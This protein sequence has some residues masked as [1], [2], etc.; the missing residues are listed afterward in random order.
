MNSLNFLLSRMARQ[1]MLWL[2]A[3]AMLGGSGVFAASISGQKALKMKLSA[4]RLTA[5][6]TVPEGVGSVTLQKFQRNGGWQ[7]VVSQ[8]AV[9]GVMTFTLPATAKNVQW[10]ALGWYELETASRSKFPVRFYKGKN[11]F[12]P[13]K[14]NG[15]SLLASRDLALPSTA[16]NVASPTT[17][18]T[19]VEADIWK[20]DGNT[21][22]FFNQLRGLQVL[23][24][25]DPADPRLTASLRLPAVGQDLYVLPSTTAD[26]TIILLTQGWTRDSG[27]WTRI[28]QVKVSGGK[29]EISFSQEVTGS[30]AD[31]RLAGNR[32]ILATTEYAASGGLIVG[33]S[34]VKCHLS[35]WL[36]APDQ[37]P[38][39]AAET[40][41][42]GSSPLIASGSEWLALAVHP[43]GQ[44]NVTDVSVFAVR[45]S[46][47]I[48]MADPIRT[49]GAVTDKFKM[50]W[51]D[52]VL[53]TISERRAINS[54]WV[55]T[56]VLENF[57]AWA[58]EVVHPAVVEQRLGRLELATGE[59]LHATRFAGDKAYVVTFLRTDPLWVV[60]LSDPANP[61]VAGQL[62]VPGW[63]S[64]LEP[65]GDMLFSIGW[66][67]GT[68]AASLFDVSNPAAPALLRRL[69]LG[70]PGTF[71]E[72]MWDE[73]ALK[74]LPSEGL[75]LI[76]LNTYD[77]L[78]SQWRPLL[79]LLDIDT[80]A[81]DLRLRG[82]IAHAFDAR[83]ADLLGKTVVSLSQRVM[84]TADITDRDAPDVL[85][86]VS[87]A[88]PVD[89]VLEAGNYLLEI[90]NGGRWYASDNR[91]T[92]RISPANS[93][94]QIVAEVDLGDGTLRTAE[95]RDGKLYV[96]RD[97]G[98]SMPM[99]YMSRMMPIF[100]G[101]GSSGGPLVLDIYDATALPALTLLGSCSITP[102]DGAQI[103]TD[104]LLWPQ[105][106]RPAV[107]LD[108]RFSY[109]F[110][111]AL[112]PMMTLSLANQTALTYSLQSQSS[113]AI[114]VRPYWVPETA[115]SLIL[116]DVSQSTSPTVADPVSLGPVG[117]M[118]N[119]ICEAANGRIVLGTSYWK[120]PQN[121]RWLDS[122]QAVQSA[123]VIKVGPT[124]APFVRP[125][126]DLP[127][128]LFAV[129]ELD[130]NGFYAFTRTSTNGTSSSLQVSACD[131][132]DAFLITSL[133]V[134]VNTV[135]AAGG[136]R[137][138]VTSAN[139]VNRHLL[140]DKG[141]LTP[142]PQL[143][144]GWA[145]DALRWINGVLTGAFGSSLFAAPG[146]GTAATTWDFPTWNLGLDRLTL[147]ADGDLLVPFGDYG[148]E[149]LER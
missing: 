143:Q 26:R 93:P 32:L 12:G 29:A 102:P 10:R 137:L 65:I 3:A 135:V 36:L 62:E 120:N 49:E 126:V 67:A 43:D 108:Y 57:R 16:I 41:I 82:G 111:G 128:E 22:Y 74:V 21:V 138:F 2:L 100:G 89:R 110:G 92:A 125:L 146:D 109:W 95:Y 99:Y 117:T 144:L 42:E 119:G 94:E 124:T 25:T 129:T 19:P 35:E 73:K 9:V 107:V 55:P 39:A 78:S 149:R 7:Q 66:E 142:E 68:V 130:A 63:S 20:V 1:L 61:K 37:A 28:Q 59:S 79:Q 24:L 90:E 77:P 4:D 46:G 50:Q 31:S 27:S 96:L 52:N 116:F 51:S 8:S 123:L 112:P 72:A 141:T 47:L 147:A 60:D 134:P 75:A 139:G 118:L 64:H 6:V 132:F 45:P 34:N 30:L 145:P 133:N 15:G 83:R 104:H 148:A 18:D 38:V 127:G 44:W 14:A 40:L 103:A 131:G 91:A 17:P 13:V 5:E 97:Q 122:T 121:N 88:W 106:N 23:D 115:P 80:S 86:E 136:K 87:L 101:G 53:T 48:R 76:P 113:V 11:K 85:A 54:G 98:T 69:S 71:S 58:P 70:A 81:R 140:N 84:V 56:T 114:D 33:N 105:P